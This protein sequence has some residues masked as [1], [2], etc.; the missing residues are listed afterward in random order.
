MEIKLGDNLFFQELRLKYEDGMPLDSQ[1]VHKVFSIVKDFNDTAKS[2][3]QGRKKAIK[4]HAGDVN[5]LAY[6]TKTGILTI[7]VQAA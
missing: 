3:Y 6:W 7:V 1:D 5:F 4:Y 2:I